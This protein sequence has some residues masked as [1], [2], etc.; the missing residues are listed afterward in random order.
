MARH[1]EIEEPKNEKTIS[2]SRLSQ[3]KKQEEKEMKI[4]AKE[5]CLFQNHNNLVEVDGL[6]VS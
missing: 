6:K 3:E 4:R 1:F 2:Q 5:L